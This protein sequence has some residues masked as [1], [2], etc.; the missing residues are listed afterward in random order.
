MTDSMAALGFIVN[1]NSQKKQ[2]VLNSFFERWK[3]DANVLDKWFAVQ[4]RSVAEN[5]L[6]DIKHLTQHSHY[7][8]I[9]PNRMRSVISVFAHGN[10]RHFNRTD[11]EGYK[12]VADTIIKMNE[13][14]PMVAARLAT[15]FESWK[16]LNINY[17]NHI[18]QQL[19]RILD[20]THNISKDV[21]E[22]VTKTLKG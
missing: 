17:Q 13:I 22:I 11:G 6:Q 1:S 9:N 18:K 19:Q 15:A 20:E 2:E 12:F 8:F 3:E 5:T 4:A 14:N 21:Y 7:S 10:T 16:V